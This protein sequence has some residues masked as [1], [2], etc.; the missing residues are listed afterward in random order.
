MRIAALLNFG[1]FL[2]N[3]AVATSTDSFVGMFCAGFSLGIASFMTAAIVF[4]F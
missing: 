2:F 1:A 3:L 4:D